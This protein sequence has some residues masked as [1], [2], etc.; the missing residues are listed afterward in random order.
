[1]AQDV[2]KQWFTNVRR[3]A[4]NRCQ[5]SLLPVADVMMSGKRNICIEAAGTEVASDT[6]VGAQKELL[7]L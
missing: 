2:T 5:W 4:R 1:M 6:S 7:S 3:G